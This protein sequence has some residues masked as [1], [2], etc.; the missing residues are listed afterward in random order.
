MMTHIIFGTDQEAVG[1]HLR[2]LRSLYPALKVY[3][4]LSLPR[5]MSLQHQMLQDA[6]NGRPFVLVISESESQILSSGSEIIKV[7]NQIRHP[8]YG[9]RTLMETVALMVKAG[10]N[11]SIV[12][13]LTIHNLFDLR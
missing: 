1:V 9:D 12:Q 4:G 10:H 3:D 5:L 11:V 8:Q 2:Y 6:Q 13:A 7:E